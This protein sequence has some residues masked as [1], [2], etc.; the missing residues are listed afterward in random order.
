M[1]YSDNARRITSL[2]VSPFPV[3]AACA[4]AHRSSGTRMVRCGVLGAFGTSDHADDVEAAA[5]ELGAD[6]DA[7]LGEEVTVRGAGCELGAGRQGPS[8]MTATSHPPDGAL[9]MNPTLEAPATTGPVLP[10]IYDELWAE[11]GPAITAATRAADTATK[12]TH[13]AMGRTP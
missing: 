8:R 2:N 5:R 13:D 9:T 11:H 1:T 6:R 7:L 3:A 4:A 10:R 12:N